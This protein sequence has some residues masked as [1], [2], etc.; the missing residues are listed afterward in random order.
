V[1]GVHSVR[2]VTDTDIFPEYRPPDWYPLQRVLALVFGTAAIDATASFWFIGFVQG[3]ADVGELR[4]Y[5]YRS[6]GR[7]IALGRNGGAYRWLEEI[8]GYSRVDHEEALIGTL[9]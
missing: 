5:E 6:T 1:R 7:Q 4:L 8:G 3:P 2:T 9:V